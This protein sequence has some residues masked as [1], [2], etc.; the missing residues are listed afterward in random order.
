MHDRMIK[1]FLIMKCYNKFI[2]LLNSCLFDKFV[3]KFDKISDKIQFQ[4]FKSHSNMF[5][6]MFFTYK[7]S[8]KRHYYI[9]Q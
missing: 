4:N 6:N 3:D 1:N 5:A 9:V 8:E 7:Y 2:C